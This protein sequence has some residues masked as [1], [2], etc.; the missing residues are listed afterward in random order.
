MHY[1]S[2]HALRQLFTR[3][4]RIEG[5]VATKHDV[6]DH[7]KTPNVTTLKR[8]R[9]MVKSEEIKE[10]IQILKRFTIVSGVFRTERKSSHEK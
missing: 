7:T 1:P 4:V 10:T 8:D 2:F 3:I 6:N 5:R 9:D